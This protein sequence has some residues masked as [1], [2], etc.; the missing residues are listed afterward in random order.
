MNLWPV[1]A[2]VKP[3]SEIKALPVR[4]FKEKGRLRSP[5]EFGELFYKE[6]RY[7]GR[8]STG[9]QRRRGAL[10]A[11]F[12]AGDIHYARKPVGIEPKGPGPTIPEDSPA[13]LKASMGKSRSAGGKK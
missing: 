13:L 11:P 6:V 10:M 12:M 8:G 5:D 2:R 4:R 7:E 9:C 3:C 1:S